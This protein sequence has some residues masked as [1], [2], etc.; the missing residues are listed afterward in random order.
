MQGLALP[1]WLVS[2]TVQSVN[3][4]QD[5]LCGQPGDVHLAVEERCD[6]RSRFWD[7]DHPN[8]C[9][10]RYLPV[11]LLD[12]LKLDEVVSRAF[13]HDERTLAD[14]LASRLGTQ[15][16]DSGLGRSG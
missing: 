5:E 16:I 11:M 14:L 7:R 9:D 1:E 6:S 8:A 2:R 10:R 13:D 15:I 4:L 12:R 3:C